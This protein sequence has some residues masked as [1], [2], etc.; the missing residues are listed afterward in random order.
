MVGDLDLWECPGCG[1]TYTH[2]DSVAMVNANHGVELRGAGEDEAAEVTA[3]PIPGH[4]ESPRR[5]AVRL[6]GWCENGCRFVIWFVQHK[7]Q[8]FTETT[9][10]AP[11]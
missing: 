9:V 5:H 8:T 7:G 6:W 3:H 1:G 2:I 10:V 4:H 11:E